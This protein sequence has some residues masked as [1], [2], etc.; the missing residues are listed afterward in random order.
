VIRKDRELLTELARLNTA[1]PSLAMCIMDGTASAAEQHNYAH[2]LIVA[3][4]RLKHRAP[5]MGGHLVAVLLGAEPV[6]AG[7]KVR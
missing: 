4:E 6:A 2:R 3:G 1:M 5:T 7:V